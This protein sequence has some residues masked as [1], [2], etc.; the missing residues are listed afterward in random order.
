MPKMHFGQK[1]T[2]FVISQMDSETVLY[3]LYML[4][5]VLLQPPVDIG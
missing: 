3:I 1:I 4:R 2:Y 5:F